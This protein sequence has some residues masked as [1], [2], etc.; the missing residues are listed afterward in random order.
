VARIRTLVA[1]PTTRRP[2]TFARLIDHTF[3]NLAR[4]SPGRR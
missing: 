1:A 3:G 4:K 2:L